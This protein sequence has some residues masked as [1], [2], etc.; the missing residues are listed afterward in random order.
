VIC[1]DE[2]GP[3]SAKG[4]RGA[5]PVRPAPAAARPAERATQAIDYGRR[6]GGYVF[7]AFRPATGAALTAPY[8]RRTSANFVAF[9]AR[10]EGWLPAEAPRVY[11]VLDNLSAH[12]APD[13]LLFSLAHPRWECVAPPRYAAYL[14]LID[15]WG[16]TRRSLARNGRRCESWAE[17]CQAVEEA[18]RYWNAHKHPFVWGHRRRHRPRR[19]PGGAVGANVR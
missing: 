4:F 12:R 19:E 13:V 8:A 14:N 3:G 6:G 17:I 1:V 7:G 16:K 5:A 15:P 2:L 9:L 10:V 18:T 11:A